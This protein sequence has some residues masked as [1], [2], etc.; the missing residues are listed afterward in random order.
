MNR[1]GPLPR[2]ARFASRWLSVSLPV[3][4]LAGALA[5]PG[6]GQRGPLYL[7]DQPP[8]KAATRPAP[9]PVPPVT[10]PVPATEAPQRGQDR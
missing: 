1:T 4:L 2:T 6:C 7:P 8:R 9:S 5:L 10:M 3:S